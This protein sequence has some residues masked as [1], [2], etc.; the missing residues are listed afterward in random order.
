MSIFGT[1]LNLVLCVRIIAKRAIMPG[2]IKGLR[3]SLI[4]LLTLVFA[5]SCSVGV[6]AGSS[7]GANQVGSEPAWIYLGSSLFGSALTYPIVLGLEL[8][9]QIL[10]LYV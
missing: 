6:Y 3:C 8:K 7:L 4:L 10:E 5:G 9:N 2:K 1:I